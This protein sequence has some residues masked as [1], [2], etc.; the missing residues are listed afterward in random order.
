MISGSMIDDLI[1]T[2][3]NEIIDRRSS[4]Q[5]SDSLRPSG[6]SDDDRRRSILE[7]PVLSEDRSDCVH[8]WNDDAT[9]DGSHLEQREFISVPCHQEGCVEK[10][11]A[12][13]A[14]RFR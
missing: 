3:T 5:A 8:D 9:H 1:V 14:I 12:S 10:S 11:G 6:F 2:T 7:F 13:A 4:I